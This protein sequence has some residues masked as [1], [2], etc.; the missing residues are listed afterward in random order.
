MQ[1]VP[2]DL[3]LD[4]MGRK[5]VFIGVS[6]VLLLASVVSLTFKGINFG[7]DFTGGTE[8]HV[9][10]KD[11]LTTA[12]IRDTLKEFGLGKSVVQE[13]GEPDKH[14]FLIR[15]ENRRLDLEEFKAAALTALRQNFAGQD[16]VSFQY[17]GGSNAYLKLATAMSADKVRELVDRTAFPG[18]KLDPESDRVQ[19][20]GKE[21]DNEFLIKFINIAQEVEHTLITKYGREQVEVL[22]VETVGPK[23]G[24]ELQRDGLLAVLA[25]LF[26]IMLYIAFRFDMKFAPG[27]IIALFHDVLITVGL[28]S[29]LQLDFSLSIVAALLAF[30]EAKTLGVI[31]KLDGT[32]FHCCLLMVKLAPLPRGFLNCCQDEGS[33]TKIRNCVILKNCHIIK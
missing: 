30:D 21:S 27:A 18:M 33:R 26:F 12:A 25:A 5:K 32:C 11:L 31:E 24:K 8:T 23:V 10:F 4:F 29:F 22:R 20:F 9:K 13:F 3:N 15:S 1:F 6:L 17:E 19:L 16:L 28:F 7:I 14:E 2:Y